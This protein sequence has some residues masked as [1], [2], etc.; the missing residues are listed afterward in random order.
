[1]SM[2]EKT[3]VTTQADRLWTVIEPYVSAEGIELDPLFA[4]RLRPHAAH[5]DNRDDSGRQNP[6]NQ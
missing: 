1:M 3:T 5:D 6:K 4:R 2:M